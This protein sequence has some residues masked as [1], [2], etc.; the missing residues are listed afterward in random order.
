MTLITCPVLRGM[1]TLNRDA[2]RVTVPLAALAVPVRQVGKFMQ[3]LSPDLLNIPRLRNVVD[4]PPPPP[5]TA[6]ATATATSNGASTDVSVEQQQQQ[7]QKQQ[8]GRKLVLLRREAI[9]AFS[10]L[11]NAPA[12]TIA[13]VS[14]VMQH[15]SSE[16]QTALA[17]LLQPASAPSSVELTRYDLQIGYDHFTAEEILRS[18]LPED[19]V[20]QTSFEQAGHIAHVNLR[21]EL[22]PYKSLIGQVIL[23]KASRIRTVVNKLN[24]I[25][26]KFRTFPLEV[27]A[28]EGSPDNLETDVYENG[29]HFHFDF[30]KVY[31]NSRLH[32]EHARLVKMFGKGEYVC[33]VMAGVGPFALPAAKGKQCVVHANDLNP[34]SFAALSDNI[35]RNKL[36]RYIAAFN[37]DGREFVRTAFKQL[38]E[39]QK[40]GYDHVVMNLPATAIEFL[41]AFKG[42]YSD[43]NGVQEFEDKV[44]M[45]M[46]HVHC[47]SN[48]GAH[49]EDEE[50]GD[51]TGEKEQA[52]KRHDVCERVAKAMGGCEIENDAETTVHNVRSVA[53]KK[54]MLCVSFR[55]PKGVAVGEYGMYDPSIYQED[56]AAAHAKESHEEH[57]KGDKDKQQQERQRQR[58]QA[59]ESVEAVYSQL[60]HFVSSSS[61]V[62]SA[63]TEDLREF[64]SD[65]CNLA[66]IL[67]RCN[68]SVEE[69]SASLSKTIAW[70][71]EYSLSD[72]RLALA[73]STAYNPR[74]ATSINL[75]SNGR[76]VITFNCGV[77]SAKVATV[78]AAV[79]MDWM[80]RLA[81]CL[82]DARQI[83]RTCHS[84][85]LSNP[86]ALPFMCPSEAGLIVD[87][88][89]APSSLMGVDTFSAVADVVTNHFP[90]IIGAV[91]VVGHSWSHS[92]MW[93][94]FKNT[95]SKEAVKRIAFM[96]E[97][98]LVR[99]LTKSLPE[100]PLT[101]SQLVFRRAQ[102][103]PLAPLSQLSQLPAQPVS[104]ISSTNT[105]AANPK[106]NTVPKPSR[107]AQLV[108]RM[109]A[110]ANRL[111][112]TQ[113]LM[114]AVE[115]AV[116]PAVNR[117]HPQLLHSV[118][119]A[120]TKHTQS[121]LSMVDRITDLSSLLAGLSISSSAS[122]ATTAV[123]TTTTAAT[124]ASAA[125]STALSAITSKATGRNIATFRVLSSQ[126][127]GVA[128]AIK[129]VSWTMAVLVR[130]GWMKWLRLLGRTW[131]LRLLKRHLSII[132]YWLCAFI[133][134]H[135]SISDSIALITST[136]F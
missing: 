98:E 112:I 15:L 56:D 76:P 82:D 30:A 58:Q 86:T 108:A 59:D 7:Q 47:F 97:S 104:G 4:P 115:N 2:F 107:R 27:I 111:H 36:G 23:D 62:G 123:A 92:A 12:G 135:S 134:W 125:S 25:E 109:I 132:V 21:D 113:Q 11:E 52:A 136:T 16:S 90:G 46:I 133:V 37:M 75:D 61:S 121:A 102:L 120:A 28:G 43:F 38:Y 124:I 35:K 77:P 88:T 70:R 119:M 129:T 126:S 64:V 93:A 40:R 60:A 128:A 72:K 103:S 110:L 13:P 54:D 91:M 117:S 55:L 80:S 96:K 44:K 89:G 24:V 9:A 34:E 41:D 85:S 32:T 81:V 99:M 95:L 100:P 73:Q 68:W 31:W 48:A 6:T 106:D 122:A 78:A 101:P 118:V 26:T 50:G 5:A 51:P 39:K 49:F 10:P 33:D 114:V 20:V 79:E 45:P 42:V 3:A 53:P 67:S 29:C 19:A 130:D 74:S 63:A 22:L 105:S 84:V 127:R 57:F 18:I 69:A 116:V 17:E 66:R 94:V 1:V 71:L 14:T 65:R 131:W 87:L 83:L 8:A